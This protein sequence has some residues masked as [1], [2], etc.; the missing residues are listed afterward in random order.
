MPPVAP[1]KARSSEKNETVLL[2][3]KEPP[4]RMQVDK[5]HITLRRILAALSATW[6]E[7][8]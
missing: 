6:V 1:A 4:M 3:R 7:V 8:G 2:R 5:P